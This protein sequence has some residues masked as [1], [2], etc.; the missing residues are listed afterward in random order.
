M[1]EIIYQVFCAVSSAGLL[2]LAQKGYSVYA[3]LKR[4]VAFI[5]MQYAARKDGI[6]TQAEKA[7]L[8]DM[9]EAEVKDAYLFAKG[10]SF[11]KSK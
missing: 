10:I 3:P 5:E 4:L 2:W 1:E 7:Q 11:W 8:Y 6:L 9:I